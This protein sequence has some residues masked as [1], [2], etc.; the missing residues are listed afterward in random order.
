MFL[1]F[2]KV[3]FYIMNLLIKIEFNLFH[4]YTFVIYKKYYQII[5]FAMCGESTNDTTEPIDLSAKNQN[6]TSVDQHD[7]YKNENFLH[8]THAKNFVT[9]EEKSLDTCYS[10]HHDYEASWAVLFRIKILRK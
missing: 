7:I 1:D 2:M 10:L 6:L 9:D 5:L 3:F 8:S 4:L